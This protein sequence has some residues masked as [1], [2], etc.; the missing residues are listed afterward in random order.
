MFGVSAINVCGPF[1]VHARGRYEY[2]I[3]FTYDYSRFRYVY[4]MHRKFDA[5][6]KFIEFK[7]KVEN[8]FG[9]CIKAL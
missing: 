6:D 2:F 9:K 4:L 1:I 5:L 3:T 8:Q 7:A